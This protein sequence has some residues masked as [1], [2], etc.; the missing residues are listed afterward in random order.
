MKNLFILF[1]FF[2]LPQLVMA[3][4]DFRPGFIVTLPGDTLK[5]FVNLQ[6]PKKNAQCCEFKKTLDKKKVRFSPVAI[7]GYGFTRGTSYQSFIL[8]QANN[9]S[10]KKQKKV[11]TYF[12]HK[13]I[14]AKVS[15]LATRDP[16][17]NPRYFIQ[18]DTI[19]K[20][21]EVRV[22]VVKNEKD[23]KY[24]K[25]ESKLYLG[26]LIYLLQDCS[27]LRPIINATKLT[28]T[29]LS[30]TILKYNECMHK[31]SI[32]YVQ[33]PN[34][35]RITIG[36]IAGPNFSFL[37]FDPPYQAKEISERSSYKPGIIG[38]VTLNYTLPFI[39][40]NLSIQTELAFVRSN[41]KGEYQYQR[42]LDPADGRPVTPV[43]F[44]LNA[45][46]QLDALELPLQLRYTVN[47]R[48]LKPYLNAGLLY[49]YNLA[50]KENGKV[51]G[52]YPTH[53]TE[54]PIT[55][56]YNLN[57]FTVSLVGGGGLLIPVTPTK[58]AL[59][60]LKYRPEF[61]PGLYGLSSKVNTFHLV[62]GLQF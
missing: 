22:N 44:K 12:L 41:F 19:F 38:G 11:E 51:T 30:K 16:S 1:A 15:L 58:N 13:V 49:N 35:P 50:T 43:N 21:L 2:A 45:D 56:L 6:S 42:F 3:Q 8:Q 52:F 39:S 36:I 5:G 47:F 10:I 62:T 29:S 55:G 28:E 25:S 27:E 17:G 26:T 23:G 31:D 37:R 57:Q 18:K 34:Q 33:K 48:K 53:K 61:I 59:L 24:Y 32:Y 4:T 20:E 7:K 60:E 9:T 46:V 40:K 54:L 14:H